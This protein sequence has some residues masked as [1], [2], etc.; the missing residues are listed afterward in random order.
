MV[1]QS[2]GTGDGN[3]NLQGLLAYSAVPV[4]KIPGERPGVKSGR[5][6]GPEDGGDEE[7]LE[8][9]LRPNVVREKRGRSYTSFAKNTPYGGEG[10]AKSG[11][12]PGKR[13]FWRGMLHSR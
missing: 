13:P 9:N 3:H 10:A 1:R 8:E 5:R 12:I 6:G 7:V 4:T 11:R 2:A